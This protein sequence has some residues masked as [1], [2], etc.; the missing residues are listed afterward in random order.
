MNELQGKVALVTGG[1]KGIG[2]A[3][4]ERLADFGASVVINYSSDS[5]AADGLVKKIND[6]HNGQA[7][8]IRADAASVGGAER[9]VKAA[10]DH[11]GKL[12]ILVPCAGILPIRTL[13][14]TTEEDFDKTYAL[15]VK[16]PYFLAQKAVPHMSAGGR[17]V[18]F[19]TSLTAASTVQPAYLLYNS[20]KGAIE[21]ITR[22][23]SKDLAGKGINVNCVAPGPTGT[24]L[25]LKGKPQEVIDAIGKLNP[26]GR[27][28]SPEEIADAIMLLCGEQ[29]RW[30]SGQV[31]RIN[32]GMA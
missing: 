29:S 6:K 5:K 2:A 25:F 20:T 17:I 19:S 11:F 22:V 9:M 16:G 4:S 27:I 30:V 1:S 18:F 32:G 24:E 26:H 21:E 15:N 23:L 10:V 31:L 8:S 3:L 28:G 13:D 12:D 7:I 14:E